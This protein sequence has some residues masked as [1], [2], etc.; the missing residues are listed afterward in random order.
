MSR[1]DKESRGFEEFNDLLRGIVVVNSAQSS[2]VPPVPAAKFVAGQ[3]VC[4]WWSPC[5]SAAA[6]VPKSYKRR[7]RPAWYVGEIVSHHSYG[8]LFYAGHQLEKQHLYNTF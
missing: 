2:T 6:D 7:E 3:S 5:F 8:D 4:Q 1:S